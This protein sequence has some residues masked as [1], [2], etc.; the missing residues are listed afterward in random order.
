MYMNNRVF[1]IV[2]VSVYFAMTKLIQSKIE[3]SLIKLVLYFILPNRSLRNA[4][5]LFH[6]FSSILLGPC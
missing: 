3:S 5:A 6:T 4:T 1:A 2:T